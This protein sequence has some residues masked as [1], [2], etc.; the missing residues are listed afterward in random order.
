MVT[1]Q[2]LQEGQ[3]SNQ[4]VCGGLQVLYLAYSNAVLSKQ[5]LDS[6][7]LPSFWLLKPALF[8]LCTAANSGPQQW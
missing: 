4:V 1:A 6:S 8:V 7:C 2:E 3:C 5:L